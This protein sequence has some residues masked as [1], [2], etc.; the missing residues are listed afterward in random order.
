MAWLER[1]R[2]LLQNL[3]KNENTLYIFCINH[4]G[5][6]LIT[7]GLCHALLKKKR[8]QSCVLITH[9]RFANCGINFVGVSEIRSIPL[10]QLNLLMRYVIAIGEYEAD[11]YIY[12][13]SFR[14]LKGKD[15][16]FHSVMDRSQFFL[17]RYKKTSGLSLDT[18]LLLPIIT[19][20]T[21]DQK[22]RLH[23]TY[24]LDKKRT[25]I[26]IPY[27]QVNIQLEETFWTNLISE[28][29][30]KNGEYVFYTNVTNPDEKVIPGTA[31]IVTTLLE[32][33]YVAENVNCFIGMRSGLF[34]LLAL[35]NVRILYINKDSNWWHFNLNLNFNHT[36]SRGFYIGISEQA[37]IQAFM[38]KH[39]IPSLEKLPLYNHVKGTNLFFD[40]D[41]ML[42]EIVD[43]VN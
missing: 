36:N 20:I 6:F 11:N 7:G 32:A 37:K 15:G 4:I 18:E 27:S 31:P 41:I 43:S 39:N 23:E 33:M 1:A 35:T 40:M 22:Q 28:L 3:T 2:K 21:E 16:K 34:D 24:V 25:I 26:L 30:R 13:R 38:E 29:V 10:E 9:E 17:G 5:D 12:M 42:K 8:K 14:R 19:P